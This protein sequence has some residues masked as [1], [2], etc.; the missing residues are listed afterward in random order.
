[1][2]NLALALGIDFGTSGVRAAVVDAQRQLRWSYRA[3]YPPH[4]HAHESWRLALEKLLAQLPTDLRTALGRIAIN[5]TSGTVL[6]CDRHGHPLTPALLYN[7]AC[8]Q[9]I[10][11][12]V[13]TFAPPDSPALSA[14]SSLSKLLRW[15]QKL[16]SD[17]WNQAVYLLHQADWLSAQ[18]HS[19]WGYSDYHNGLKLGY[20]VGELVYPDWLLS[21]PWAHLLPKVLAPGQEIAPLT[22]AIATQ[23][24]LPLQCQVVAGTTD[25]IAAFL[26]SGAEKIGDGVTS[27]GSTLAIKLLSQQ[28][29]ESSQYGIY[30]H[31]LGRYWLAGG[32]S[33]TGGAVLQHFFD[34][35]TLA[36]L[37]ERIDP[38]A[39]ID[40]DYYPLLKPGERFPI[41][42]PNLPPRLTPQP[43]DNATFLHGLLLGIACI[44]KQ[45]Y[46]LLRQLGA[47]SLQRLYTAGGG[48]KN[49]T[50]QAIRANLLQV[51]IRTA[52]SPEAAVGTAYLAQGHITEQFG[53]D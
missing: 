36:A 29:I 4:P 5:G 11:N 33:N 1:M 14:T 13:R 9:E 38:N 46:D 28:R 23:F 16:P 18:L 35:S 20:D 26:A 42:D 49:Q 48:A 22:P 51:P 52:A 3:E 17:T 7:H 12:H 10:V 39:S 8:E 32:A 6:L 50:W 40:L 43:A 25:S 15:Q 41:N 31:R 45:G 19:Q 27:L 37:S 21:Q 44:E 2:G 24:D 30:S 34:A 47:S 53:S